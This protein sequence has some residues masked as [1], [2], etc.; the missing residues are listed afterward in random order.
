MAR[1]EQR[2]EL[3]AQ[4]PV[5]QR[6]AVL[7]AR[8]HEHREDVVAVGDAGVVAAAPDLRVERLVE[9]VARADEARPWAPRPEVA[10][11]RREQRHRVRARLEQP[12]HAVADVREARAALVAED[13]AQDHVERDRL[14]P[15]LER[16]R[17]AE[18]P[19]VHVLGGDLGHQLLVAAQPLAV[20]RRQ[21]QLPLPQ[22]LAPVEQQHGARAE[23]R[24]ERHVRLARAELLRVGRED[25]L[26]RGGVGDEH[27]VADA[28]ELDRERVAVLAARALHERARPGD[29]RERLEGGRHRRPWR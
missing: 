13:H 10:A 20:E 23:H 15:R 26:E 29:P 14:H 11:H 16:D 1:H 21:H 2:D 3:V 24:L 6:L 5:R 12:D 7:V 17:C 8:L 22:V 28:L 25:L 27:E 18:R 4:L 19:V 9:R